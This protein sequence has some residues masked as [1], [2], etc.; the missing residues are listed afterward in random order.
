MLAAYTHLDYIESSWA[1]W[2][3]KVEIDAIHAVNE[4]FI[5]RRI[6]HGI[7]CRF[8]TGHEI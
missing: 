6:G 8:H 5:Q 4:I 1:A 2:V 3:C 7:C